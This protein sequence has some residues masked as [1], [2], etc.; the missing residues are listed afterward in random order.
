[1][2][3][4][5]RKVSADE[6]LPSQGSA[7]GDELRRAREARGLTLEA[8]AATTRIARRHLDALERSELDSLPPGPFGKSYLRTYATLLGIDPDP[9]LTAYRAREAQRGLG[10]AEAES[11]MLDEFSHLVRQ[12]A[13]RGKRHALLALGSGRLALGLVALTLVGALGWSLAGARRPTSPSRPAAE[14][15]PPPTAVTVAPQAAPTMTSKARPAPRR[16]ASDS[17]PATTTVASD[18]EPHAPSVA[19][20]ALE[21]SD[22]GV[23]TGLIDHQLVGQ[24]DRFSEGTRVSFQTLVLGG[25]TGQVV[26]HFWFREGRQVMRADLAIGSAR[27]RTSSRLLLPRGSAG[28]WAVEAR[29]SDGRLLARDEFVCEPDS[30]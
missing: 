23:G 10:T 22:H 9:I 27:W 14:R 11:R 4:E 12:R 16:V 13:A 2:G 20:A 15:T 18:E 7:F 28:Q 30:R 19:V 6:K 5:A 21:V 29:S 8:V 26:R 3:A 1:M 17:A 25:S 24:S